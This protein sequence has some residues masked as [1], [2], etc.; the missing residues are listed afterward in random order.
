M[1]RFITSR[2]LFSTAMSVVFQ[3]ISIETATAEQQEANV[4]ISKAGTSSQ[5]VTT[6]P[7]IDVQE[8]LPPSI[9]AAPGATAVLTAEEIEKL[10]PLTLHDTLNFMPGV[11][12]LDDD[13]FGRRSGIGIRGAPAR[14]SRKVLLMEDGTPINAS[15]YL[16]PSAHYTPPT[17][18]LERVD[19][20]KGNGQILY[21]PL[22]NHGIINFRNK[23]PT[24]VPE[25]TIEGAVGETT[26]PS[27]TSCIDARTAPSGL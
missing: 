14:R 20:L 12:T 25:T 18:R 5:A 9:D 2:L 8:I 6:L 1:T 4:D 27:S 15:T 10:R 3:L 7:T 22:N 11:R 19:V 21:G 17:E 24:L 13:V 26:R 16:D 23:R